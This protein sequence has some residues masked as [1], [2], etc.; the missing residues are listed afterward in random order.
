[1][2]KKL[3]LIDGHSIMFRAF[4]GMPLT[5]T[6]PDGVHTNAVYGFL[7][8]MR[9]IIEEEKPDYI[10]VAFD[11]PTPTFRHEK[12]ADY[13]GNRSAAPPEFHEQMPL[14]RDL[15][16]SMGI[17]HIELDGWEADDILGTLSRRGE[18]EDM[19]VALVS[20]DRDLLQIATDKTE[21]IL[22]KTKGGQTTY[23]RYYAA[24]VLDAMGVTPLEFIDMKALMG[25]S[26]DNIPGLPGVGPKTASAIISQYH[27]IENAHEHLDEIKPKKAQNSM[28]DH[29]D[30]AVLSKDLATIRTNA[31]VD[32]SFDDL[33]LGDIYNEKSYEMFRR[34]N[35]KSLFGLFEA[36]KSEPVGD[37]EVVVI[38]DREEI[39][40]IFEEA[41]K[42]VAD[43]GDVGIDFVTEKRVLYAAGLAYGDKCYGFPVFAKDDGAETK[44]ETIETISEGFET[45]T[46]TIDEGAETKTETINE[47]FL[48]PLFL[49]VTDGPGRIGTVNAK[50]IQKLLHIEDSDGFYDCVIGA[51]LIDPLKSDWEY[52]DVAN[53]Y[54]KTHV[55]SREELIGKKGPA[56]WISDRNKKG[57]SGE[58]AF[59]N[60]AVTAGLAARTGL[61]SIDPVLAKLEDEGMKKLF[62]DV[63]MP[64][65]AV[66]A[67]MENEGIRTSRE[68]L[69][70]YSE[71]LGKRIDE[72]T[73]EI[74]EEAGE[75]FNINSPKQ[76]GVILFEKMMLPGAKKTKTGYSTAADVLEKLAPYEKIVANI[77]E[78]RTYSKLKSTYADGL[79]ANI[80]SDGRIRTT[81][82]QTI[83]ATGRLSSTDPNLQNIPMREDLGRR[84][85]KCFFPADGC[86]FV[87]ADYSQIELRVLAHMSGDEKLIEAYREAKDIHR[88]TASQVFHVPFDEV[89]D[90]MRRNA[91][92]VNFGI[93]YGISSFGLSQ[94][95][96]ISR[97]EAQEYINDY[98]RTY[99]K[100]KA[101]LDGLV[102]SA[103]ETGYASSLFGRKRPVPELK[104]SN[105]MQRS[106]GE[107][108]AMN[109][110]IQGTAA[111]II[112]IAM[113]RVFDRLKAEGMRSKLI[114]QIHDELLIEA[115]LDEAEKAREILEEEM[116]AAAKL[117]VVLETDC[118]IGTDWYEAK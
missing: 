88:T 55:K 43:G 56:A 69:A 100:I 74:Y 73:N 44:T 2:G 31:P 41:E 36:E 111:D 81:F 92:A 112:K 116:K 98:F 18:K 84:I 53:G 28:R 35:F 33:A 94:G 70:S 107:R 113:A 102:I 78:Y 60:I 67:S 103:R 71:M 21:I 104:S 29:Y 13:K 66:L 93:V 20:G 9:K 47:G 23:E 99:P 51:Y 105:F 64:L 7:A 24:D 68:E 118:H 63:E 54:L 48:M 90:Q 4:Y 10:A 37:M 117:D 61:L 77:L 89:T 109:S 101:F 82:N 52:A 57:E 27:S 12:F 25:D 11:R 83:T 14:I 30:L 22:P 58:A 65:T 80:E 97:N 45:K 75:E 3:V 50:E 42:H 39:V 17:R 19:D 110:P 38:T 106:F 15:L 87:D 72:L 79:Q 96:S 76:L 1:M 16:D 114:L 6:A 108:V 49:K 86:V 59:A 40:R 115:P 5:M 62:L 26:S 46:E 85:R 91:K 8:I 32:V 34:L 95:L